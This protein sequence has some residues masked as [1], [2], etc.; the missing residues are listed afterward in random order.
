MGPVAAL[1]LGCAGGWRP[2]VVLDAGVLCPSDA[3]ASCPSTVPSYAQAVGPLLAANCGSCHEVG[4]SN[5]NPVLATAGDYAAH[6]I[7]VLAQIEACLMPPPGG[8]DGFT[9][10]E[11]LQVLTWLVCGAPNN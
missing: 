6:R 10:S 7:D 2:A 5:P 11:R 9:V 8:P 1:C 4:G 3:P